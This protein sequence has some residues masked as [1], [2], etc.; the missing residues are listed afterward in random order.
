MNDKTKNAVETFVEFTPKNI[1]APIAHSTDRIRVFDIAIAAFEAEDA[2]SD[3]YEGLSSQ[4]HENK[5]LHE[6]DLIASVKHDISLI[7]EF[8][9]YHKH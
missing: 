7:V 6:K 1:D 9:K 3:V 5:F 4:I 8:L 2:L